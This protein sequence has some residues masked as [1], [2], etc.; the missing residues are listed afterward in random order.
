MSGDFLRS[1]SQTIMSYGIAARGPGT[2]F[3]GGGEVTSTEP[4]RTG[5]RAIILALD[6]SEHHDGLAPRCPSPRE[7]RTSCRTTP[8]R[9]RARR[10]T[11]RNDRLQLGQGRSARFMRRAL[12]LAQGPGGSSGGRSASSPAPAGRRR[13]RDWAGPCPTR[14]CDTPQQ[15]FRRRAPLRRWPNPPNETRKASPPGVWAV[16]VAFVGVVPFVI[17]GG[18]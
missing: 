10:K 4:S 7:E 18:R 16:R 9:R 5:D 1:H 8:A 11:R 3:H 13:K 6:G 15:G 17:F 2:F 14:G 12:D